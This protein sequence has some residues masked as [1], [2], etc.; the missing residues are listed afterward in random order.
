VTKK[1]TI[2]AVAAPDGLNAS[3]RE[4]AVR[5]PFR[6]GTRRSYGQPGAHLAGDVDRSEV[7]GSTE[8]LLECGT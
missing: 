4:R 2:G 7:S 1:S 6:R 8:D 5:K 3:L